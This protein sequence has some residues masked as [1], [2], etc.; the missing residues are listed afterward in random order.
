LDSST[1]IH[2]LEAQLLKALATQADTLSWTTFADAAAKAKL[3]S[4]QLR[5]AIEW[6]RSKELIETRNVENIAY[7]LG[8][9]GKQVVSEGLPERRLVQL[10]QSSSEPKSLSVLSNSLGSEF[11]VALGRARKNGWVKI[12]QDQKVSVE[13]KASEKEPEE[14]LLEKLERSGKIRQTDFTEKERE[15][16]DSLS[17]RQKGLVQ[18]EIE[19]QTDLK[20]TA[21]G[22]EISSNLGAEEIQE[23]TPEVIKSRQWRE[24]RLRPIDV[25]SPTPNYY[26]G[27]KHP[28]RL[29]IEEVREA[30]VSLG[31]KEIRGPS[32][33][34]AFWNFDA[35]FIP[36]HHLAREMQ[37]TFYVAGVKGNVKESDRQVQSVKDSH[38]LGK[39]TGSRAWGKGWDIDESRK[40]VLRTHTTAVTIRYLADN[41][42]DEAR[43]FSVD[44]VY[45]NEK[46]NYKNNPEFY[47]I[48]GVMTAPGLNLRNLIFIISEFY[49]KLGFDKVKFWPTYFPYTEPSLQT[50]V[51]VEEKQKW[52]E[53]GGMGIFR[54]EV[55]VPLGIKNPVLAWGLGMDR[56]VMM[57]YGLQDIRDLFGANLGWLRQTSLV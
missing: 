56:L 11:S 8:V 48:E 13:A 32:S 15:I 33:Q 38:E 51:Y 5:R 24:R 35:L 40:V 18:E 36:Q 57:K 27:R 41:R 46:P 4:D 14:L 16:L 2:P 39:G 30:F 7:S 52:M 26:G 6:L 1:P 20:L 37:D 19:K 54:P 9:K 50:V 22:L 25:T 31:F 47:Q 43:V 44:K 29:F 28:I 42:P 23:I 21:R 34:S 3:S 12:G 17:K 10:I 53:L 55:T 49:S 45:R